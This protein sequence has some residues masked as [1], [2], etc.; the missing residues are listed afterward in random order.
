[1]SSQHRFPAKDADF[2][3][4][5]NIGIPYLVANKA[6][7]VITTGAQAILTTVTNQLSAAVT[8]WNIIYPQ[9][10]NPAIATASIIANKSALRPQIEANLRAIFDDIP[11]SVLT[12]VDRDTLNLPLPAGT[13]TPS[14]VPTAVPSITVSSR[15]H[16]SVTLAIVDSAH[17]QSAAKP[18]GVESIQLEGAFVAAGSTA[19]PT[20][21][22]FRNIDIASKT[23]YIRN[24]TSDQLASTEYIRA[25]YLNSRGEVGNWSEWLAVVV[26]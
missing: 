5:I 14:P 26:A 10:Q 7:L 21:A 11:K 18:D 4:Y 13:H 23:S 22:D 16:L 24:Y 3:N 25:R 20:D 1:M 6:R 17:P 9:S 8:G 15:G 12:Q 2:N 19:K